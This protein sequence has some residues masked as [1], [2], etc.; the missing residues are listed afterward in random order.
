MLQSLLSTNFVS[1]LGLLIALGTATSLT[2]T[3]FTILSPYLRVKGARI[4]ND[5]AGS[6]LLWTNARKRFQRGARDIFKAAFAQ[7]PDAFYIMTDT[8][9]ELILD[10]K[11]APEVRN[12]PRF[13]IGKYNEDMFHGTIAGFE[14]FEDDHVLE[15][16]F[17]ETVRN[18]LTRAIGKFVKPI[19]LEAA[20]GLQEYWTDETEWHS[21]PLHQSVLRTIAKQS[22][23]VFQGAPLCYNPD[24]LRITVNHTVTFFEAAE[25]LKVWPHPLRPLAAKVLPLCRK[26]RAEAEEARRIIA[27]VLEERLERVR[28]KMAQEKNSAAR[29][30]GLEEEGD[31]EGDGNMI[32]WAE[33]TA[34]GAI[35]DAALLQMKVSLASIHTTSDLVSQTLFNLCSRPELVEDLRKEVI[36]VIGQQGWVKPA[37]YQLKLMDS[38]LKETQRLKPISIGT[39]VRTTTSPV[40]FSDGLQVPRNTRTLVSCHNMWTDSVHSNPEEFDGYRFLKLRRLPG[41]E[42]WTQ[43]VSTSNKHLGFGHGMHACPGRFF[44]ATTAKVLIAHVVLKYDLKLLDGHRPDII[45]HGAAQYANVWCPIGVRRREEEIDLALL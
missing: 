26:L 5:R 37:L 7:H 4:F 2:W 23:R 44:A 8:D 12:D 34:N 45:E 9:V 24:W 27:P 14:M 35:Y 39:M 1:A 43:L 40:T 41:Q 20:D 19:S 25:S 21:L 29:M 33:E 28:A 11:Y 16:V 6:E 36:E 10:S 31:D 13:D 42:N 38:V 30:T 18:K 17:V 15:R 22:S 32:E 3:A